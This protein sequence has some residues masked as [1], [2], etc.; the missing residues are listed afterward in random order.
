MLVDTEMVGEMEPVHEPED[1][2]LGDGAM[3][4]AKTSMDPAGPPTTPSWPYESSPQQNTPV[5]CVAQKK[6]ACDAHSAVY[7][8]VGAD[9]PGIT[10]DSTETADA[11][12]VST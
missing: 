11:A 6:Y 8:V 4:A 10:G 12:S 7:P 5:G 9:A 1:V 3:G 2:L